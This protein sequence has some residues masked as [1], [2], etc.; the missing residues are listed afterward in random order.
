MSRQLYHRNPLLL[1]LCAVVSLAQTPPDDLSHF[2]ELDRNVFVGSKPHTAADFAFLQSN[3][4]RAIVNARFW[5]LFSASEKKQARRYGMTLRSLPLSASPFPP[6]ERH[7]DQIL[8]TL[9]DNQVQPVYLHC[10][11]GRDRT[12]LIAGLYRIYVLGVSRQQ[13]YAEMKQAGFPSW[14]GV[15]GLKWY[16]VQHAAKKPAALAQAGG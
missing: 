6:F 15:L 4:V 2:T 10:V 5:P 8:L 7:V 3:H 14:F 9:R 12:N 13:A 16:F 1:L 11:L